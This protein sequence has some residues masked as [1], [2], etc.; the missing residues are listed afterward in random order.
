M[1]EMRTRMFFVSPEKIRQAICDMDSG[2]L[3]TK[4]RVRDVYYLKDENRFAITVNLFGERGLDVEPF[5]LN[6]L[7]DEWKEKWE[8]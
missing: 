4:T 2:F 7:D 8:S 1:S 5:V 6:R 3:R